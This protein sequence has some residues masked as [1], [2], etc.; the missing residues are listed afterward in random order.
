MR[1]SKAETPRQEQSSRDSDIV[2]EP[3]DFTITKPDGRVIRPRRASRNN[4]G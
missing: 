2:A 4:T 3:S 1:F